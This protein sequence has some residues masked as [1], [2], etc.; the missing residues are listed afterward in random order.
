MSIFFKFRDVDA[1][2]GNAAQGSGDDGATKKGSVDSDS[3]GGQDF[4]AALKNA[5]IRGFNTGTGRGMKLAVDY[6]G[7]ILQ[8]E[9]S[10]EIDA[11]LEEIK[12]DK[13]R[14]KFREIAQ[15]KEK[16]KT[17]DTTGSEG[18]RNE[19]KS[20]KEQEAETAIA[21]YKSEIENISKQ[22]AETK[23]TYEQKY[24]QDKI[25]SAIAATI[26]GMADSL[27]SVPMVIDHFLFP[28]RYR[29]D[30]DEKNNEVF[31]IDENGDRLKTEGWENYTLQDFIRATF[32]KNEA[33]G[34]LVKSSDAM[35]QGSRTTINS[36]G[37]SDTDISQ[38][39][40]KDRAA[41]LRAIVEKAHRGKI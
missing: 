18:E 11:I 20:K 29:Y 26:G 33:L 38:L 17:S 32:Q 30:Y 23:K 31:P 15:L 25:Q 21:K 6:V 40:S 1:A 36:G 19:K 34:A 14:T 10:E 39:Y 24:R 16:L 12:D 8:S 27:V 41:A 2:G 5:G 7:K 4:E 35:R 28:G 22:L 3:A 13:I 9:A 37:R